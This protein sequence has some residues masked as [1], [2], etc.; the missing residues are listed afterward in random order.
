MAEGGRAEL[1][2]GHNAPDRPLRPAGPPICVPATRLA[3]KHTATTAHCPSSRRG[4]KCSGTGSGGSER[5]GSQVD[6][7]L[8]EF[9]SDEQAA[10]YGR[11]DGS[12]RRRSC[13]RWP[14]RAPPTRGAAGR[15]G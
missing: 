7:V 15:R 8:V 3:T 1:A 6:P 12:C 2:L 14:N 11:F 5:A 10:A 9:L 13:P 4:L